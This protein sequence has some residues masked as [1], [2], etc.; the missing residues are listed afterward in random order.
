MIPQ[1]STNAIARPCDAGLDIDLDDRDAAAVGVA[2]GRVV[3]RVAVRMGIHRP[4][5][6]P[7][8]NAEVR[9][10]RA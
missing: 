6:R 5:C 9:G 3:K 2:L 10:E 4:R 7:P 8:T 1:S